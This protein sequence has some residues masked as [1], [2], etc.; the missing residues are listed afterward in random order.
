MVNLFYVEGYEQFVAMMLPKL[1][2]SL[3]LAKF[4]IPLLSSL[5]KPH[6]NPYYHGAP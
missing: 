6:E 3:P 5:S 4:T 1:S 2:I